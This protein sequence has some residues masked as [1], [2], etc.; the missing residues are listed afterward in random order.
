MLEGKLIRDVL[1]E[2]HR[3]YPARSH[4]MLLDHGY[5]L[6][7]VSRS[8]W[9]PLLLPPEA[10]ARQ[11]YLPSNFLATTNPARALARFQAW[12]WYALS[13]GLRLTDAR[14]RDSGIQD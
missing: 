9:R 14:K 4:Q 5:H 3:S 6:F 13:A 2:E 10:P 12:G 8:K 7:R 1:F 11:A